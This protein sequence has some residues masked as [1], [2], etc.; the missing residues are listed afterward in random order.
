M[1]CKLDLQGIVRMVN[2]QIS[3]YWE[4]E[5]PKE[6]NKSVEK[7]LERLEY[8]F[9]NL[10]S[11]YYKKEEE[12]AFKIE[13][14]VQYSV[15]LYLLANQLWKDGF[16]EAASYAYYLNKIMNS[17]DW[18]YAIELPDMFCAEHPVGSVLGR[19]KWKGN[20]FFIYQGVTVGGNRKGDKL[21]YPEF[22][23]NILIYA[24]SKVIGDSKLGN[25]VIVSANALIKD[26]EIPDNSI[27][28]GQSPNLVIKTKS[29]KEIKD[30]MSHIWIFEKEK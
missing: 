4:Y 29:E 23:E 27:V 2:R 13:H 6:A 21:Y 14:S 12:V 1:W 11:G 8:N 20:R 5:L 18:F 26:E 9:Q 3:N 25:N 24:D 7:A 22:G 10:K 16:E 28:F 17:V 30:M 15:F 19:A